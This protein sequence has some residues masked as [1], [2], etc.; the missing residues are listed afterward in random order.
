M[1]AQDFTYSRPQYEKGM[2]W[3]FMLWPSLPSDHKKE[4]PQCTTSVLECVCSVI[5]F[6][7]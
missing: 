2:Q 7:S 3:L 6:T 1:Y 5:I 4:L